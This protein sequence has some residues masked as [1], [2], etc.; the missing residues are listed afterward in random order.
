M[1]IPGLLFLQTLLRVPRFLRIPG[2]LSRAEGLALWRAAR[3][4]PPGGHVA[5]IGSWKGKSTYCLSR[6]L[7]PGGRI[8]AIDPFDASGDKESRIL[9]EKERGAAELESVFRRNLRHEMRRHEFQ[10][11][12]GTSANFPQDGPT[13]DLL[14]LDGDHSWEAVSEDFRRMGPCLKGGGMLLLH[15]CATYSP[16]DGPRKLRDGL[17]V[18]RKFQTLRQIDALVS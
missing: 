9:Y 15:D 18:A 7:R 3:K 1:R 8:T 11:I 2:Y 14:F 6:G 13:L 12:R 16:T 5:E 10:I 17:L 4:V